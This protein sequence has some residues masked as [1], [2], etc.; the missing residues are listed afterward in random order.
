[1]LLNN[2][3]SNL[4]REET[5]GIR[6]KLYKKEAVYNFLQEKDGL[7][8]KEQKLLNSIDRYPKNLKNAS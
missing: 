6:N 4:S 7:T 1:M 8:N 2:L 3:R 5:K